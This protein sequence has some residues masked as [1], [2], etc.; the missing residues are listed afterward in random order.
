MMKEIW[1]KCPVCQTGNVIEHERYLRC[2]LPHCHYQQWKTIMNHLLTRSEHL[3]LIENGYTDPVYLSFS[4]NQVKECILEVSLEKKKVQFKIT[5]DGE[6]GKCPKCQIG[7]IIEK[8]KF[9][10][11]SNYRSQT[12][13][14]C[15]FK[16][17]KEE[18]MTSKK[19]IL[20]LEGKTVKL[21]RKAKSGGIY[22][23]YYALD[24]QFNL[25]RKKPFEYIEVKD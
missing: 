6:I 11:C 4:N 16:I 5:N 14:S 10:S 17:W 22:T 21:A 2:D 9:Y 15:S 25:T 23:F 18:D 24:S 7:N 19:V 1:G 13:E 12:L 20:L 8:Y 3:Q